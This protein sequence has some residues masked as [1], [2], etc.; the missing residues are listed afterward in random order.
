MG[1]K[2]F[3]IEKLSII[4]NINNVFVKIKGSDFGIEEQYQGKNVSVAIVGSGLPCHNYLDNIIDF[5][6]TNENSENPDDK[7]GCSSII[8]SFFAPKNKTPIIGIAPLVELFITKTFDDKGCSDN[9]SVITSILWAIVKNVDI[10]VLPFYCETY[11]KSINDAISKATDSGIIV[12]SHKN[13]SFISECKNILTVG[14]QNNKDMSI[15]INKNKITLSFSE[16]EVFSFFGS[17]KF[18]KGPSEYI[19]LGLCS[20]LISSVVEQAKKAKSKNILSF[21]KKHFKNISNK[22]G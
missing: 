6:V 18:H 21:V 5:D 15:N 9:S 17:K 2:L 20:S 19:T 1:N 14:S 10:I 12:I 22:N 3:Q 7:Y 11:S 13:N 8:S 16:E 4:N